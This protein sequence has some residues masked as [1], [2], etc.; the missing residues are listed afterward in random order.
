MSAVHRKT[1]HSECTPLT[2][3][4]ANDPAAGRPDAAFAERVVAARPA[5]LRFGLKLTRDSDRAEDLAQETILRALAKAHLYSER[6][7]LES[8]L[9]VILYKNFVS[10]IRRTAR[11]SISAFPAMEEAVVSRQED[12]VLVGEVGRCLRLI[13]PEQAVVTLLVGRDGY[14]YDQAASLLNLSPTTVR[15]RLSRGRAQLRRLLAGKGETS[16]RRCPPL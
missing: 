12:H 14:S 4:P 16:A 5:L 2:R 11:T 7:R 13:P 6:G 9:L 8:W 1:I 3:R 10:G 15:S